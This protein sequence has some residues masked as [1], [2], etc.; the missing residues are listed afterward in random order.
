MN[1]ITDQNSLNLLVCDKENTK[2][3]SV[4]STFGYT[5]TTATGHFP[6]LGVGLTGVLIAPGLSGDNY[7]SFYPAVY[8]NLTAAEIATMLPEPFD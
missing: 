3:H 1:T 7:D 4:Q 8:G 5:Y 6:S 2:D